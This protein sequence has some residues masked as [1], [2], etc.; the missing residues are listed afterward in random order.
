M[1]PLQAP[2]FED[3]PAGT[4]RHAMPKSVIF[5]VP[6][7]DVT[8]GGLFGS[9]NQENGFVFGAPIGTVNNKGFAGIANLK[10]EKNNPKTQVLKTRTRAS[11]SQSAARSVGTRHSCS[12][13]Y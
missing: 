12:R 13:R 7:F 5:S 11:A 3:G 2:R 8:P 4:G 9:P 6:F 1:A 10:K